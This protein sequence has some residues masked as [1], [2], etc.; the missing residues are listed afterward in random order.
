MAAPSNKETIR[1]EN[2]WAATSVDSLRRCGIRVQIA[3]GIVIVIL[4]WLAHRPVFVDHPEQI[5]TQAMPPSL[6]VH[7]AMPTNTLPQHCD[8][9]LSRMD[10]VHRFG[11]TNPLANSCDRDRGWISTSGKLSTRCPSLRSFALL[12]HG[13]FVLVTIRKRQ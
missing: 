4:R 3:L 11:S 5:N 6:L 8:H 2:D 9:G 10:R 1:D 13:N 7:S 12:T